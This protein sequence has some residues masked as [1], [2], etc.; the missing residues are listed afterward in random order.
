MLKELVT[1]I[2]KHAQ[3]S[4]VNVRIFCQNEKLQLQIKDDGIGFK[5]QV[6]QGFGLKGLSER[7]DKLAG[8]LTITSTDGVEINIQIPLV[9]SHD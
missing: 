5:D 6:Q 7:I 3:A 9:D 4:R 1:N 8:S 2:L